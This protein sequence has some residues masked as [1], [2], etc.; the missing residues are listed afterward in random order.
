M[1]KHRKD[2]KDQATSQVM[3]ESETHQECGKNCVTSRGLKCQSRMKE[4]ASDFIGT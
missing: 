4:P 3:G 1:F 2:A